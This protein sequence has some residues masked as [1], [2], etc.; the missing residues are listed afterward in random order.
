MSV[1]DEGSRTIGNEIFKRHVQAVSSS[2]HGIGLAVASE[3]TDAIG[4]HLVL[5]P[6]ERTT[7]SVML[8][9]SPGP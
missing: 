4:G 9:R 1:R 3:I 8:P 2:G 5:E 7:F 6:H